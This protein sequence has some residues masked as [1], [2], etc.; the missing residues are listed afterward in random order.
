VSRHLAEFKRAGLLTHVGPR[1]YRFD[2]A[3]L[4]ANQAQP[5]APVAA[6]VLRTGGRRRRV[7]VAPPP[8]TPLAPD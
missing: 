2:A 7:M 6:A 1:I 8:V 4:D 5:D 3:L